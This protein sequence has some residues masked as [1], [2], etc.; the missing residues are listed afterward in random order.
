MATRE[1]QVYRLPPRLHNARGEM[2]RVGLEVELGGL[3]LERTLEVMQGVLG[4]TVELESRTMGRVVDTPYGPF[5][6]EFDHSALQ[7]RSY[8]RPLERIGLLDR[9]DDEAKQRIEDSVLRIAS[10]IVPIEVV[11]PPVRCD[12]LQGLDELWQALREAGAQDT[13]DSPLFAF[14]LHLNP[15]VPA[16][17]VETVLA[18]TRAYLLLEEWLG[19]VSHVAL[20]RRISPFV[21]SFPEA[22]RRA[23][24][25]PDYAPTA[26]QF[27]DLYLTHSPTR[28]RSLDLL[29]LLVHLYGRE[30]L[31]RV[32]DAASV[33]GRPTFHYRLPNCEIAAPGWTPA[34]DWN[35]WL[36]V[37]RLAND[38]GLLTL[39]ASRYLETQAV[40]LWSQRVDWSEQ[41]RER[42]DLPA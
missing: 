22:Y 26:A 40:S 7:R 39:L 34:V 12:E 42:L 36:A 11:S 30:L 14:G 41:L 27:V 9:D 5:K 21:R 33:K 23:V 16:P 8:L 29:P 18:F 25:Q 6:V 17:D 3:S 31:T 32:E 24:L 28:N 13:Y 4:G 35:R 38:E 10:E 15:E 1:Q 19:S 2:R 37:E 20:A